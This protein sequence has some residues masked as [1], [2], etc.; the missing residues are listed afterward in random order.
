MGWQEEAGTQ[1]AVQASREK[2][3]RAPTCF[4]EGLKKASERSCPGGE[5]RGGAKAQEQRR[6]RIGGRDDHDT[7]APSCLCAAVPHALDMSSH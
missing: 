2:Q 1:Q 5:R 6:D 4:K 3:T 7:F